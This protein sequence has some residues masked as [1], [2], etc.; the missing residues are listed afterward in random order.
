MEAP[1]REAMQRKHY[2]YLNDLQSMSKELPSKYQQRISY[3]LLSG[4]A[5]SLLDGTVFE[6]VQSLKDVQQLEE[7]SLFSQRK[8]LMNEQLTLKPEMMKKHK[9]AIQN[10][11]STKPHCLKLV[12]DQCLKEAE[13]F[14]QKYVEEL[15]RLDMKII[16]LLDQKVMDQQ[17]T[18][19][20]AGVPGFH[21]TNNPNEVHIQMYLLSFIM[22]LL[23]MKTS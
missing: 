20:K 16:M 5:H 15:K 2:K 7:K 13:T 9:E 17:V 18:L 14:V 21:V 11:E 6:I 23:L 8:K 3:D 12:K 22:R 10:C 1:E 19:E 4:L